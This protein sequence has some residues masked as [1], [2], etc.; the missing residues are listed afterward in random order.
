[1]K[2]ILAAAALVV[3]SGCATGNKY[4][5]RFLSNPPN[6]AVTC[7]G[8]HLGYTPL[9]ITYDLAQHTDSKIAMDCQ[10]NWVSGATYTYPREINLVKYPSGVDIS[11][12]RDTE[13]PNIQLDN[14][15]AMYGAQQKQG[16]GYNPR[17]NEYQFK[18]NQTTYCNKIGGQVFCNTY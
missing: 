4:P 17:Q 7:Y 6:A 1:M 9:T 12:N 8:K 11:A 3:L 10:A 18:P 13:S 5:I 14:Q 16:G 15:A 2:V